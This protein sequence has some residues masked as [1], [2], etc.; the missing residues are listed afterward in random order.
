MVAYRFRSF[1]QDTVRAISICFNDS[2]MNRNRRAFDLAI[3]NDNNGIPGEMIYS[4]ENLIVEPEESVN[5]FR[6][7]ILPDGLMVDGIFYI[8]WRQR[9][10]TFL[11]VGFDVNTPHRG[12][13]Y[14]WLNGI[15]QQSQKD[16]SIMIRPL[17]GPPVKPTSSDDVPFPEERPRIRIWPNPATDHINIENDDISLP[18]PAYISIIDLQGRE[19]LNAPF[20][21]LLD[22]SSLRPGIYTVIIK[23]KAGRSGYFRLIKRP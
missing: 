6:T 13:Q 1:I 17:V 4:A 22:I 15:W 19:L 20:N 9:S 10:E 12:R 8:G 5:G 3:W 21:E 11:N 23:N 14:F 7:Y 18:Q 2:Y 16:G